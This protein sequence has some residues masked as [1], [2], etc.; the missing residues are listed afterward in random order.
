MGIIIWRELGFGVVLLLSALLALPEEI[1]EAALLDG[2]NWF[3]RH[4]LR[5]HPADLSR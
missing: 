2:A 3:Q 1:N 5:H 4:F